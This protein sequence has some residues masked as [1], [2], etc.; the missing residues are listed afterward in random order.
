MTTFRRTTAGLANLYLF[1]R[2]D[3]VVYC[4]GGKTS[5][6]IQALLSGSGDDTTLDTIF[7]SHVCKF[8]GAKLS[9]HF[10]SVGSRYV[11]DSIAV[12]VVADDISTIVVCR[13]SD[14]SDLLGTKEFHSS[15]AYTYGYSWENDVCTSESI[16]RL[17]R[18]YLPADEGTEELIVSLKKQIGQI[19]KAIGKLCETDLALISHG[20]AGLFVRSTPIA[21]FDDCKSSPKVNK[22]RVRGRL[23]VLGYKKSPPRKI[24]VPSGCALRYSCGKTV[25]GLF[26]HLFWGYIV[27][28]DASFKISNE[29]FLRQC[30]AQSISA[31]SNGE[32]PE[33]FEH[34]QAFRA[35]FL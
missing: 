27:K 23:G 29:L 8:L 4:E 7:W 28:R 21:L 26:Y 34:Y 5:L 16:T 35:T 9:Y 11:L 6:D 33:M 20:K 15:L 2:V 22:T 12:D 1:F 31:M 13:D 10:K 19:G 17:F 30:I 24:K 25:A 14:F 18:S 3:R 32:L